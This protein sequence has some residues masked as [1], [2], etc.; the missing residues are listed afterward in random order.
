MAAFS[1]LGLDLFR[2]AQLIGVLSACAA[3]W[4]VFLVHRRLLGSVL[5]LLST[6]I[7]IGNPTFLVN[8]YEVGTDMFFFALAI[9]SIAL[10][11]GAERPGWRAIAASGL[12]GG[13]AF[14]TRYNGLFLWP[15]TVIALVS[16]R[17]RD[18][19]V[20]ARWGRAGLW[21]AGFLLAATPWLI[22][23][24]VHT[25]NPLTNNNYTNVGF[26]VYGQ[27]N[28]EHF[29]YGGDRK[30]HSFADVVR[31]DPARFARAMVS[32][33]FDASRARWSRTPSII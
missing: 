32:N 8:V 28:W 29:F 6:L 4:C 2:A 7:L 5:A 33:T 12:L 18:L 13:W 17:D 9:G 3:L 16:I 1:F 11:L 20:S 31:L 15:G 26:S 27:G 23:N 14:I 22:V 10:L 30:I 19:P 24:A 25:G 21:S